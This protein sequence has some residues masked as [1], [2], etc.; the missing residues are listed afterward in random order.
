GK[1]AKPVRLVTGL[2]LL[3]HMYGLSDVAVVAHWTDNPYWQLFCGYDY[4]QWDF[5]IHPTTLTKW[6]QR[7]GEDGLE[8]ILI[9]LINGALKVG[10]VK[11]TSFQ[12]VIVDTTVM[13]KAIAYPTDAK[14]FCRALKRLVDFAKK[15]NIILRQSYSRLAPKILRR[16]NRL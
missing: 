6:R 2:M 7:L 14:L 13:P 10:A 11:K 9:L 1:C 15:E 16:V 3:Q 12:K 4:L 5:P 8:K